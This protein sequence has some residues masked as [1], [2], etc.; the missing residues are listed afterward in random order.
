[1][2]ADSMNNNDMAVKQID[3]QYRYKARS[4]N[5]AQAFVTEIITQFKRGNWRRQLYDTCPAVTGRSAYLDENGKI[6]GTCALDPNYLPSMED[7]LVL[8][9]TGRDYIWLGDGVAA[10]LTVDFNE[11]ATG[12]S[13]NISLEF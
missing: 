5:D 12:L 10:R 13:Y 11:D 8:M 3:L 7:W 1:M 2:Y 9:Q 6:N 4:N